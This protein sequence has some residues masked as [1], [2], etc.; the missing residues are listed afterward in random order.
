MSYSKVTQKSAI[1]EYR[2]GKG[3][4][5]I[6]R[7]IGA[8]RS[9]V[10]AW[11]EKDS[12]N[13]HK[14][15]I[16]VKLFRELQM[17]NERLET[18]IKILKSVPFSAVNAPLREKLPTIENMAGEY[19][20][21]VLC[22]ALSVPKGTYYNYLNRGKH[23]NTVY[24]KRRMEMTPIIEEVYNESNHTYGP[25]KI[26]A[27]LR[28]RGFHITERYVA[29]IMHT[30][31]WFS[32]RSNAK[33][34][35]LANAGRKENR[36]NQQFAVD[37]PNRVWVSDVTIFNYKRKAFY[38]CVIL[39]IFSRRVL[40]FRI[41]TKNSTQLTKGTFMKAWEERKPTAGLVFHSD[42]GSNYVSGGF[43]TC[44]RNL[45]V[46]QSFSRSG[47]PYDNAVCE[48]FFSSMKREEL[49]LTKYR[50][51][52]EFRKAVA[53]YIER[54]NTQRPHT[55]LQYKTPQQVEADF[56]VAARK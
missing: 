29:N 30:N 13:C 33:R 40:A 50:S 36:V 47:T 22:E 37:A 24:A 14:K 32:L 54:Y 35:F 39:D 56:Q 23:G 45:G 34:L 42:R 12:S 52:N 10:Y 5:E 48:S 16:N 46:V 21:N 19:S 51:E 43:V 28:D 7:E 6:A 1:R 4:T 3:V 38:I 27:V 9:T 41:S 11:L 18:I 15:E 8:A 44:L 20:V 31:G 49:Y 26:A 55:T 2:Q 17:R 53:D 25:G